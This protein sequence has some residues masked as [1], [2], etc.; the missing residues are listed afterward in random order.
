[1]CCTALSGR[2]QDL[3]RPVLASLQL[4]CVGLVAPHGTWDL[5][6]WTRDGSCTPCSG[7]TECQLLDHQ[8]S[9]WAHPFLRWRT[10]FPK[11]LA[12]STLESAGLEWSQ[13]CNCGRHP[14]GHTGHWGT[15]PGSVPSVGMGPPGKKW[16]WQWRGRPRFPRVCKK[17]FK[18]DQL[19]PVVVQSLSRVWLFSTPWSTPVFPVLSPDV[20]SGSGLLSQWCL[21]PSHPVSSPSPPAFDLSQHQGLFQWVV[22]SH[23]VDKV[24]EFQLQHQ[25]SQWIFR[26]DFL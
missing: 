18:Q 20:R 23:Q 1:M 4:R 6:S 13:A 14:P 11:P 26:V 2:A 22:S 5:N 10:T 7:S 21:Q 19:L 24:L 8:G 9:F 12:G 16:A 3:C 15:V 17:G 25:S